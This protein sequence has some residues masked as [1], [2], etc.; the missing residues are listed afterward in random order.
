MK[1]RPQCTT[2]HL[3][4]LLLLVLLMPPSAQARKTLHMYVGEVRVM[5]MQRID[6]VAIGNP[7]VASNTI[8]PNG[9]LIVLADEKGVTTM[10]IWLQDGTEKAFDVVVREKDNIQSYQELAKLLNHM[11][12]VTVSQIDDMVVVKGK[13]TQ[14]EQTELLKILDKYKDALNLAVVRDNESIIGK[15]LRDVPNIYIREIDGYTVVFGEISKESADLIA[16][17]AGKYPQMLDLTRTQDAI[18]DQMIHMKVRVMEVNKSVTENLGIKWDL[19]MVGPSFEFGVEVN[20]NN[21]TILNANGTTDALKKPANVNDLTT[22]RGYFGIATGITSMINLSE[23]NGDAVVLAEPQLS[24]RSGGK[25]EFLAGGEYP[26]PVVNAQG[27]VTVQF[28]KYGIMLNLEPVVDDQGNILAH[29]ETEV[30]TIDESVKVQDIPGLLSR[31]TMTEVSLRPKQTLVIAG[32]VQD[33]VSKGY[34]NVKWLS[35]VPILGALFRSKDFQNRRSELV[36]FITPTIQEVGAPVAKA[37][38][39]RATAIQ[40]DFA[41]LT[42]GSNLLE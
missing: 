10:H 28:K 1:T 8:L 26:M 14:S 38:Q 35:D 30:S 2:I 12:G 24:T 21:G 34:D 31:R 11:P 16:K 18:V 3:L 6:R 22:A 27:Q 42:K 36:I 4:W 7:K 29:V 32:L 19:P 41:K 20:Q 39:E 9:Q 5:K 23:K 33:L 15:M 40:A 13:T 25:A 37:N 17:V